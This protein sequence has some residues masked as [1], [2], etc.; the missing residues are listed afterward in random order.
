MYLNQYI[1]VKSIE[2]CTSVAL[3]LFFCLAVGTVSRAAFGISK[4]E[5]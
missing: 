2:S 4:Q 3:T 1:L 5:T